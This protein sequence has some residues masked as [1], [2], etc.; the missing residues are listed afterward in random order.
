MAVFF[1][2]RPRLTGRENYADANDVSS[3]TT[4]YAEADCFF[5]FVSLMSEIRDSFVKT[6]DNEK[7]GIKGAMAELNLLLKKIDFVLWKNMV[8]VPIWIFPL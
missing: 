1:F 6:L 2:L 8:S 7:S 3:F 4:G 5:C